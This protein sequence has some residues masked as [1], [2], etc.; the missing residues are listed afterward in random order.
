MNNVQMSSSLEE[1]PARTRRLNKFDLMWVLNLFGTAVGAGVLFLPITAG[2]S[3]LWPLIII[4]II[5][6]PMTYF[7]HRGLARFV[8]ASSSKDGDITNVAEEFFGKSAGFI[9]TALYFAAIYPILLIYGVSITNTVDSFMV[10]QL[11]MASIPRV[12]LAGICVAGFIAIILAGQK[13]VLLFNEKMVY[14]LCAI[15]LAMSLYLIPKWNLDLFTYVPESGNF[16]STLWIT[17]PVLVFAFNHSPAISSC[18]VS[19]RE[20]YGD[21]AEK[22]TSATLKATSTILVMFVMFFV[23]SCVLSLTTADLAAAREQNITILSYLANKYDAPVIAYLGPII[24]FLA[25]STS[26][27]G[28]YMGAREGLNGLIVKAQHNKVPMKSKRREI[29]LTL[30]FFITLWYVA[31]VNP[32][33]LSMIESLGGPVIAIILFIMPMY[34]IAKIPAMKKYQGRKSNIFVTVMGSITIASIVLS[35]F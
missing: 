28:H 21:E 17:L 16:L 29:G 1:T 27:F 22:H 23:F 25:I 12:V 15:L 14:P 4:C 35:F 26:F 20:R 10:N 34:A 2:M 3:G 24:A 7:A 30:F 5:V 9:I 31:T 33:I 8:L 11:H 6:G 32:S 18:A 19:M 13:L